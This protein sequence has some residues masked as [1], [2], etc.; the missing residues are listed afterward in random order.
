MVTLDQGIDCGA[1]VGWGEGR[2]GANRGREEL[3]KKNWKV[4]QANIFR[5]KENSFLISFS[6]E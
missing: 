5:E 1:G 4:N 2:V 3:L 6:L